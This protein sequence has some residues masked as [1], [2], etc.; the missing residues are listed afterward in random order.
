LKGTPRP[1]GLKRRAQTVN[2]LDEKTAAPVSQIDREEIR[3]AWNKAATITG[4]AETVA[5]MR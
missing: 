5:R 4:H 2:V 1:N 3:A